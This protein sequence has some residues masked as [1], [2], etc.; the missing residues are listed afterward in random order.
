MAFNAPWAE[1]IREQMGKLGMKQSEL[2]EYLGRSH[3]YGHRLWKGDFK[4]APDRQVLIDVEQILGLESGEL[5][6]LA[7]Y[8][9]E[10]D[11]P[12]VERA[13]GQIIVR[14]ETLGIILLPIIHEESN[15]WAV[16]PTDNRPPVREAA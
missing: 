10:G 9:P 2:G 8:L 3:Q 14:L 12:K 4:P 13:D 6:V 5:C 16:R 15:A 7:G 11:D 1:R